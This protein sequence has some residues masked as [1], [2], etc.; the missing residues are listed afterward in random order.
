MSLVLHSIDIGKSI[1]ET[2]FPLEFQFLV[3]S[4]SSFKANWTINGTRQSVSFSVDEF[5]FDEAKELAIFAR[6]ESERT[7]KHQDRTTI[8]ERYK[9]C[10]R[11]I[12]V[13]VDEESTPDRVSDIS[14]SQ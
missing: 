14:A 5:G 12:S 4:S 8:L 2:R 11:K 13:R 7:G 3:H 10:R 9:R 1:I 6:R